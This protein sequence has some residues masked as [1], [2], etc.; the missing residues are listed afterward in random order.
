MS[1]VYFDNNTRTIGLVKKQFACK[2][3]KKHQNVTDY[4]FYKGK[5]NGT[6][7]LITDNIT[8]DDKYKAHYC[9]NISEG[10]SQPIKNIE[11]SEIIDDVDELKN[12]I[13]LFGPHVFLFQKKD[14]DDRIIEFII[15]NFVDKPFLY[16]GNII[17]HLSEQDIDEHKIDK[18]I[19]KNQISVLT[20]FIK[21]YGNYFEDTTIMSPYELQKQGIKIKGE[22]SFGRVYEYRTKNEPTEEMRDKVAKYMFSTKKKPQNFAMAAND[23]Y[24]MSQYPYLWMIEFCSY[25]IITAVLRYLDCNLIEDNNYK[26][27]C[28]ENKNPEKLTSDKSYLNYYSSFME[29]IYYP[30]AIPT[31]YN[32]I[33]FKTSF[34]GY[35]LEEYTG[36][37]KDLYNDAIKEFEKVFPDINTFIRNKDSLE[38]FSK[39]NKEQKDSILLLFFNAFKITYQTFELL[40]KISYINNLGIT[41]SHRD[42]NLSNIMY[43]KLSSNEYIMKLIDFGTSCINIK[44]KNKQSIVIGHHFLEATHNF[45]KCDK[46]YSDLIFFLASYLKSNRTYLHIISKLID[47]NVYEKFENVV[48]FNNTELKKNFLSYGADTNYYISLVEPIISFDTEG[49]KLSKL[50]DEVFDVLNDVRDAFITKYPDYESILKT[51]YYGT[52][53]RFYINDKS[54]NGDLDRFYKT[55]EINKK[56]YFKLPSK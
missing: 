23:K 2:E 37:L 29:K 32:N 43:K 7:K 39:L 55:Y 11:I 41:F 18:Q 35:I 48:S 3:E 1:T 42:I 50:F 19:Y 15:E 34:V 25:V 22:G 52:M 46:P 45:H 10:K 51:T 44:F 12:I 16:N 38:T 53:R 49:N 36:T 21:L 4:E 9:I 30:F 14:I 26:K 8:D 5:L 33:I 28:I 20:N 54:E 27:R 56:S 6:A 17:G 47:I 31:T 24:S 40:K 13:R